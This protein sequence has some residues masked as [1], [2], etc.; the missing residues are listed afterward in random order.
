[1]LLVLIEPIHMIQNISCGS[2]VYSV[3][4]AYINKAQTDPE[5]AVR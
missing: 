2:L 5:C 3:E 1:M 4:V